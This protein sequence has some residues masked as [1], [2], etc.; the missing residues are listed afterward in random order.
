MKETAILAHNVSKKFRLFNSP[1][2]RLKEAL[3][4]FN[5]KYHKEFW[6][7][8]DIN[9]NIPK[10]TTVGIIGR[11]GSGKSTL[12]HILCS[13]LRPTTGTV[14]AN[15]KVSTLLAMGAGFNPEFTGRD[16]VLLNGTLMGFSKEEMKKRLPV[17]EA[18]ADI[19]EFFDQPVKIYSSGMFVR[20]AFA[21]AINID[22]D[23]LVIDEVLAVGDA[24][25]QHKCYQKIL[26]FQTAGKTCIFVTHS[27]DIVT[28]HCDHAVL[29]DKGEI[30]ESGHP[31][32][33]VNRYNELLF[34]VQPAHYTNS[35]AALVTADSPPE[36]SILKPKNEIE[37]F[38][39]QDPAGDGCLGRKSYNKNEYRF[40]DKRADL[41]D[42]LVLDADH[43][44]P[45]NLRNSD[46]IDLYLKVKYH[47]DII[48]PTFGMTIKTVDGV[49]VYG[50]STVLKNMRCAPARAG[51]VRLI[52][53]SFRLPLKSGDYFLSIGVG[54]RTSG[55]T[56]I[57]DAR[58]DLIHLI[59]ANE[60]I[61]SGL[62]DMDLTI[63]EIQQNAQCNDSSK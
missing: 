40:G 43:V 50:C 52:K 19:G 33:V 4:P 21:A 49:M 30:I 18:F 61:F 5:K 63:D 34:E 35:Q 17:I 28:Q 2:E 10:G 6:A 62:A 51:E 42:F 41:I 11:N 38:I 25:F 9:L 16:N 3:H 39:Q 12:L 58:Y 27:N 8:K 14:Y 7:L 56:E 55:T 20:V 48:C 54:D 13:I 1:Q 29:L 26:D 24:K 36:D 37:T 31:N 44:D 15:G 23:I 53:L 60:K 22:P 47:R 32:D 59:I 57:L 46:R 45:V